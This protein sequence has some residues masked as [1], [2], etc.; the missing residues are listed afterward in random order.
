ML[1]YL[2]RKYNYNSDQVE[3][4]AEKHAAVCCLLAV[5]TSTRR[6]AQL[7]VNIRAVCLS[8]MRPRKTNPVKKSWTPRRHFYM[9]HKSEQ[10]DI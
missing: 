3:I 8:V 10:D 4:T 7:T 1:I 5:K 6:D 9:L 2:I